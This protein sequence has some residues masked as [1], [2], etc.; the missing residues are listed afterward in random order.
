MWELFAVEMVMEDRREE[1]ADLKV[2][3]RF[4]LFGVSGEVYALSLVRFCDALGNSFLFVILPLYIV[5]FYDPSFPVPEEVL[6]GT[7]IAAYGLAAAVLQP[8]VSW[9]S[10]R[11]GKRKI[12]V[13]A[14]LALLAVAT[15]SFTL[16][17]SFVDLALLRC[18]QGLGVALN[19][20]TSF[21]LI[22]AHSRPS[23]RGASMGVY[24]TSRHLGFGLGPLISGFLYVFLGFFYTFVIAAFLVLLGMILFSLFVADVPLKRDQ[25]GPAKA[26]PSFQ[27]LLAGKGLPTLGV[28][29]ILIAM[30]IVLII[31]L[32]KEINERLHLSAAEFGAAISALLLGRLLFQFPMGKLADKIGRKPVILFGL[33]L[34]GPALLAVGFAGSAWLL[35]G[36]LILQGLATAG[37][38]PAGY[39]LAADLAPRGSE[40]RQLSVLTTAFGV[41]LTIGPVMTGLLAGF[42]FF[43]L[44]FII[45]SVLAVVCFLAVLFT[46]SEAGEDKYS[47]AA[48]ELGEAG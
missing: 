44:P 36:A 40:A 19:V 1:M 6:I 47:G 3:R 14:G 39:A 28:V 16:A 38:G 29:S 8:V 26:A 9:W 31:P 37:V 5:E 32:E 43:E 25:A 45:S 41:G 2:K 13:I 46:V 4:S 30:T 17:G 15:F 34:L 12:F 21:A 42:L 27:A 22:S 10:D 33:L 23:N 20:P 18:L 35:Y 7:L 48:M 24:T 11:V